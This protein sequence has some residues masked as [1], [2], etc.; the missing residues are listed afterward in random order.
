MSVDLVYQDQFLS[1]GRTIELTAAQT[2]SVDLESSE[3]G[4]SLE[5]SV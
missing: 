4:V 1:T 5:L 2:I 3:L